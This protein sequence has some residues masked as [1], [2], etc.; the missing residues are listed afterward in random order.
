MRTKALKQ[1]LKTQFI[2]NHIVLFKD[3]PSTNEIAKEL[4]AKGAHAGTVVISEKQSHGRGRLGRTWFSPEGGLWFSILL[5]PKINP[6]EIF[7]LTF[8]TA[9]V[10]GS[11]LRKVFQLNTQI[12]WPNDILINGKKV[13][14]ILSERF[15]PLSGLNSVI[16]GIGI[17]VNIDVN[18]FPQ[19]LQLA[20]TSI[21]HEL[22]KE[23][24]REHLLSMLLMEFEK[25]YLLLTEETFE[26]ILE[27]WKALTCTLDRYIEVENP[28][29][30][31]HGKAIDIDRDG[32]LLIKL[33]NGSIHRVIAGDIILKTF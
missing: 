16:V 24:D 11:T 10:I 20:V 22:H 14:G 7:K 2:G 18:S 1:K 30:T 33:E 13:C 23:I 4:A 29:R 28:D 12:K 21:K 8:L 25:Y 9:V 32:A 27:E 5:K 17:N 19:H 15:T 31:I 6:K 26:P 3:I